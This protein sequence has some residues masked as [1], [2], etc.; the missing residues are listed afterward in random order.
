MMGYK[1]ETEAQTHCN[2]ILAILGKKW[3]GRV[4]ENLGWHCAWQN[5]AVT[6]HRE[7]M[8]DYYFAFVGTPWGY[9]GHMDLNRGNS[10]DKDPKKAIMKACEMAQ[11][12]FETEWRPIMFSVATVVL[13]L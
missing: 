8:G 5:G 12:V 4:W 3:K 13:N 11:K 6:L 1:T 10:H 9:G 2:E 7:T